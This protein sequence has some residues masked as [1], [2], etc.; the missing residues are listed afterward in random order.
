MLQMKKLKP[1]SIYWLKWKLPEISYLLR[2]K[3]Q[4][5]IKSPLLSKYLL[6]M[7][8]DVGTNKTTSSLTLW[9]C[10]S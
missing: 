3:F 5:H 9:T 7:S 4:N 1:M 8:Y 2:V 6:C 10:R